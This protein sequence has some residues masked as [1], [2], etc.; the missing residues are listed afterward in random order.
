[1]S[2]FLTQELNSAPQK[3]SDFS[4]EEPNFSARR[5]SKNSTAEPS[6]TPAH[7]EAADV[8]DPVAEGVPAGAIGAPEIDENRRWSGLARTEA[9][10]FGYKFIS[11]H[12]DVV[13]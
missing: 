12:T 7:M 2:D 6:P 3:P 1:M 11:E 4:T 8:G 13:L 9:L 5:L 10:L